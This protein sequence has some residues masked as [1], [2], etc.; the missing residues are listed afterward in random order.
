MIN[1]TSIKIEVRYAESDQMGVVHHGVYPQY[2]EVGRV[3]WLQQYKLHYHKLEEDGVML[4]VY[5]LNIKYLMSAKFGETLT[6]KTFIKE[7]PGVKM[8]FYYEI[9]NE[10]SEKICEGNTTL[11]FVDANTRRPIK[12]PEYITN[13]IKRAQ[14]S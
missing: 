4:P 3:H 1:Q 11:V 9:E 7:M 14:K 13:L 8:K 10:T 6:I 5:D 12:C 2:F